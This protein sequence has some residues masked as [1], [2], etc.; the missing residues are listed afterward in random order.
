VLQNHSLALTMK[1][2][3]LTMGWAIHKDQ[4]WYFSLKLYKLY[5]KYQHRYKGEFCNYFIPITLGFVNAMS[6][7]V[8]KMSTL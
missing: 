6:S 3:A 1:K 4:P 2:N 8:K 7:S 5:G